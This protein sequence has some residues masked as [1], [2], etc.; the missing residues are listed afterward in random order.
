MNSDHPDPDP[1]AGPGDD[2]PDDGFAEAAEN[3]AGLDA[4]LAR[5]RKATSTYKRKAVR[6]AADF[7]RRR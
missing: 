3:A 5:L 2:P 7:G 6:Y 1:E 4:T